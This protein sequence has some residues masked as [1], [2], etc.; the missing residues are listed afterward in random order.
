MFSL[1]LAPWFASIANL[2]PL[3]PCQQQRNAP[4]VFWT[5]L[6]SLVCLYC[7]RLLTLCLHCESFII[8]I[9]EKGKCS[10]HVLDLPWLLGFACIAFWAPYAM[11]LLDKFHHEMPLKGNALV[12]FYTYL[13]S[14]ACLFCF[15][16]LSY[17]MSATEKCSFHVLDLPWPMGFA[18]IAPLGSLYHAPIEKVSS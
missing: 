3:M 18:C 11:L 10:C 2:Y 7:F 1:T 6:G 16:S 12:M 5:Y 9:L 13:G 17:A 15:I 4:L 8:K 14:L